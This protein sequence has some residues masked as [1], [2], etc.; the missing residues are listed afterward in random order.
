MSIVH[1]L[2]TVCRVKTRRRTR[3]RQQSYTHAEGEWVHR[4]PQR[5]TNATRYTVVDARVAVVLKGSRCKVAV[6]ARLVA[7]WETLGDGGPLMK[8]LAT[9][10][11]ASLL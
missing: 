7:A 4:I 10:M 8:S 9:V 2:K 11:A 5:G 1:I 6:V 3:L